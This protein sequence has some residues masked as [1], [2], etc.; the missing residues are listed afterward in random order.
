M[1]DT[2]SGRAIAVFSLIAFTTL[3]GLAQPRPPQQEAAQPPGSPVREYLPADQPSEAE[4]FSLLKRVPNG[5]TGL[6]I[7]RYWKARQEANAMRR[8]STSLGSFIS[9]QSGLSPVQLNALGN[10]TALGPG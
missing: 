3:I 8:Y 7:E 1:A 5:K 9:E 6:P 4:A 10:W 2:I